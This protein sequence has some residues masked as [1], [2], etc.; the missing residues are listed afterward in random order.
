M[1]IEIFSAFSSFFSKIFVEFVKKKIKIVFVVAVT[2][3]SVVRVKVF[4]SKN[5]IFQRF[6]NFV[7]ISL[8]C[9]KIRRFRLFNSSMNSTI[10]FVEKYN[11][12]NIVTIIVNRFNVSMFVSMFVFFRFFVKRKKRNSIFDFVKF[13]ISK[14][15]DVVFF[16]ISST[17]FVLSVF[18][19]FLNVVFFFRF[20]V[21]SSNNYRD[22]FFVFRFRFF[23]KVL[24]KKSHVSFHFSI[25]LKK[26]N[27][28]YFSNFWKTQIR[29]RKL[30]KF[31]QHWH[32]S[33]E[34]SFSVRFTM[35][36][37]DWKFL[38]IVCAKH[39]STCR[40]NYR[41]ICERCEIAHSSCRSICVRI[42]IDFF[43]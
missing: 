16:S 40:K 26:K 9:V 22:S 27:V 15:Y 32:E 38:Y 19:I 43:C 42:Y 6:D 25:N 31:F 20:F 28:K 10:S 30:L 24:Q 11:F 7:K 35:S 29:Q 37:R 2:V 3:F 17:H 8:T 41:K 14:L 34:N 18:S 33:N 1:K 36:H 5:K 21:S 39:D 13:S 4:F 12:V 23:S